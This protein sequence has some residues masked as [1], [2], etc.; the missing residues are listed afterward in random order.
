[1]KKILFTLSLLAFLT[2]A[3]AQYV[4]SV[5]LGGAYSKQDAHSLFEF[6]D[7]LG[8]PQSIANDVFGAK[9][10]EVTAGA[11]FGY[12]IGR[13]QFGISASYTMNFSGNDQTEAEYS[14]ANPNSLAMPQLTFVTGKGIVNYI[15]YI[16]EYSGWYKERYSSFSIAPYLRYELIQVGDVAFFAE[17]SGYFSKTTK[18]IHHDYLEWVAFEMHSTVDT[19]F[20]IDRSATSLGAKIT[21]GLSWQ[22]TQHCCLDLYFDVLAFAFDKTKL[23]EGSIVDEYT[24]DYAARTRFL[25][26]RAENKVTTQT[27]NLGFGAMGIPGHTESSRNWVRV[28]FS[29]TF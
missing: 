19:T 24:Y 6:V 16:T 20:D 26:R 25:N 1:M 27:T 9:N 15:D 4:V 11:K 5:Q 22:L 3:H 21:P 18:P 12:Q 14:A 8:V 13:V 2:T 29:Y 28:G 23:V 17:L 10:R 7:T